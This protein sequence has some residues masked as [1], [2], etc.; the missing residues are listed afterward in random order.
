MSDIR[1]TIKRVLQIGKQWGNLG[2]GDTLTFPEVAEI[3]E[4]YEADGNTQ[5]LEDAEAKIAEFQSKLRKA[6]GAAGQLTKRIKALEN[7]VGEMEAVK[8]NNAKLARIANYA[9]EFVEY[10]DNPE[11]PVLDELGEPLR[12]HPIFTRLSVE[13]Q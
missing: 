9:A 7:T 11:R 6:H 5:A 2:S 8:A 12:E 4:Y 10:F 13:V 1:E 3:I